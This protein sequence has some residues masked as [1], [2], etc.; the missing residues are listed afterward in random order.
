M[1]SIINY[2]WM[3]GVL[4]LQSCYSSKLLVKPTSSQ[5]AWAD[6]EIGVLIHFDINIF[7]TKP[8]IGFNPNV[9]DLKVFN[10]QKLNTDQWLETASLLGAKY[11]IL[12]VNAGTGFSLWPTNV[13]EYHVGNTPWREGQGDIIADFI[14]SCRKYG[15]KPGLYYNTNCNMYYGVEDGGMTLTG[16]KRDEFQSAVLKQLEEIWAN[17]GSLFEIWFD[18]GVLV[19][20]KGGISS[21]VSKL[22]DTYQPDAIMMGG[23]LNQKNLIRCA[24][25]ENG[26][27]DYPNWSTT[28]II[29]TS[30]DTGYYARYNGVERIIT[31]KGSPDGNRWCPT[32]ALSPNRRTHKSNGAWNGGWLW[33]PNEEEYIKPADELVGFYYRSVGGNANLLLGMGIDTNGL[34]PEADKLQFELAGKEISRRFDKVIAETS[35]KGKI[36][37]LKVDKRPRVINHVVLQENIVN[38][39]HIRKYIVE[40]K[41]DGKWTFLCDGEFVGHKRI[42]QFD[43][44]ITRDIRLRVTEAKRIPMIK[45]LSV[46]YVD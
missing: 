33:L 25:K 10:P 41:I 15:I 28:D 31:G 11:A 9:P 7:P 6:A 45:R 12:T 43:P 5:V 34:F 17:Y 37:R 38:G 16:E 46:Y 18:G 21:S 24:V 19:D 2:L 35:G 20:E 3:I 36:V 8:D 29:T 32:E 30:G 22:I 23:P 1:K 42:H 14:Q 26:I 27:V 39:E 44:V 4:L 13:H 40:A